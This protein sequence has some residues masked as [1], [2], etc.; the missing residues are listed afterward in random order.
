MKVLDNI[1][2]IDEKQWRLLLEASKYRSF[3]Q[4]KACYN[5]YN[6]NESFM[7]AFCF[8]VEDNNQ[9]KGVVI[10]YVQSDGGKLKSFFSRRAII[11]AGPLLAEDISQEAL[12]LLLKTCKARLKKKAIYIEFRNFEDYSPYKD[13][14]E[15]RGFNYHQHLNFHVCTTTEEIVQENLGKSRKRDIKT[16]LKEGAEI[17]E[18]PS[19]D[20]IRSFYGILNHLYENKIKTPLFP[21]SF[22]EYLYRHDYSKFLLIRYNESIIGGTVCVCLPNHAVYEWFACGQDGVYK[23]IHPSTL[24][25]YAGIMYAAKNGFKRFD[26]MG[27]GKPDQD[28]GVREFKAKFGGELVQHGRFISITQ[29]LLYQIGKLGVKIMKSKSHK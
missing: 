1:D 8:A 5:L 15:H 4:T 12:T 7:K 16:S 9:L 10:G 27:A 14:F 6:A 22:F 18:N 20:E 23:N 21:L 24:A 19:S 3:F 28:Y 26:M 11:N 17:V 25:T 13:V 29:P 2:L